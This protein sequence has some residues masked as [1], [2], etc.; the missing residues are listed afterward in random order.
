MNINFIVNE[1]LLIWNLLYVNAIRESLS[2]LKSKIARTYSQEYKDLKQDKDL[3]LED[4]KNFIPDNDEIYNIV[5]LNSDFKDLYKIAH[6]N[7]QTITR[8]F[9][10]NY[11][12]LN[13]FIRS[14]IR[15]KFKNYSVFIINK[16]FA[17]LEIK[18]ISSED[19]SIVFGKDYSLNSPYEIVLDIFKVILE[20]EIKNKEK[21]DNDDLI[22]K[23]II[24]LVLNELETKL[25]KVSAYHKGEAS[26]INIKQK[27][28]PYFLMY[29]GIKKEDMLECISRDKYDCNIEKLAYEKELINLNLEDFIDFCIRNK[30]Y[31]VRM[32]RVRITE[33]I[34]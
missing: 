20:N 19:C 26:L 34:I 8:A 32:E 29:L 25:T 9:D 1:Y 6:K 16:E 7:K 24:E 17:F 12:L 33:E 18:N 30:R 22:R 11:R 23:A 5:M 4:Y 2:N 27:L 21:D 10:E 28:Y 14:N 13:L 31:I 15:K 3:I